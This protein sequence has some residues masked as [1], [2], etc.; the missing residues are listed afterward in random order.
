M[1]A[2]EQV[3]WGAEL[4][5]DANINALAAHRAGRSDEA[6]AIFDLLIPAAPKLAVL[7]NNRAVV[8]AELGRDADARP[9]FECAVA[10]DPNHVDAQVGLGALLW[11]AG[12]IAP[13][14]A[15]YRSAAIRDP[16]C[17]DAHLAIFEL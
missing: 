1:I 7:H 2:G 3:K 15:C 17:L 16:H 11:R 6:L 4:L 13:A 14:L 12:E 10:L 5:R 8:L 9:G